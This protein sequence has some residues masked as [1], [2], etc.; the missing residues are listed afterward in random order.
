[1]SY[2]WYLMN[3]VNLAGLEIS[4]ISFKLLL[5]PFY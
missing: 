2:D 1:M 4:F 3:S 5:I